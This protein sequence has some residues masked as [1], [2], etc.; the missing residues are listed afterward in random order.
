MV[1]SEVYDSLH[2]LCTM[3]LLDLVLNC[4]QLIVC[5]PICTNCAPRIADMLLIC[6]ERDFILSDGDVIKV[7]K[8]YFN[9]SQ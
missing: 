1:M 5:I 2:Y 9:I 8:S 7:V 4:I 6:Y 3:H